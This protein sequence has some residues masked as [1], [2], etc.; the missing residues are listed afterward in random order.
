LTGEI[1]SC[2]SPGEC[3]NLIKSTPGE[4]GREFTMVYGWIGL[5]NSIISSS[6]SFARNIFIQ[7]KQYYSTLVQH[8]MLD[9][10]FIH[11]ISELSTFILLST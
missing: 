11:S 6:S 2:W 7:Q 5:C 8:F 4:L 9:N 1:F 3:E 10:P